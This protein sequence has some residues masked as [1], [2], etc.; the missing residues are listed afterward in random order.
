MLQM[1]SI[2]TI[3]SKNEGGVDLNKKNNDTGSNGDLK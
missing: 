1:R 2:H 3:N